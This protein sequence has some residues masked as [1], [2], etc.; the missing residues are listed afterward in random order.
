M[1]EKI[2]REEI[3]QFRGRPVPLRVVQLPSGKYETRFE[4]PGFALRAPFSQEKSAQA[5]FERLKKRF[6][7]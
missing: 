4:I 2:L 5:Y 6:M 3:Y 7:K 1:K